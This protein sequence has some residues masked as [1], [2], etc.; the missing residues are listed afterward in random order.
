[1]KNKIFI[2]KDEFKDL[3]KEKIDLTRIKDLE[4]VDITEDGVEITF[5]LE[6]DKKN[7]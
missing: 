6:D 7:L 4:R 2:K 3:E 1:M 5:I